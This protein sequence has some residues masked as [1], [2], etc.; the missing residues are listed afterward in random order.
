MKVPILRQ[1][2]TLLTSFQDD[3]TDRDAMDLQADLLEMISQT[4]ATSVL[5]DVSAMDVIDS[6][7]AK[8][9][10]ETAA[11]TRLLGCEVMLVGVR[12]KVAVSLVDLGDVIGGVRLA[13]NLEDGIARLRDEAEEK[14]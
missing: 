4:Q 12:P 8:M 13:L 1:G 11:M 3:L 7:Q 10:S 2:D 14:G 9:L 6:Y 5:M